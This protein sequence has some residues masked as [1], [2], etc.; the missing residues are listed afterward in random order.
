MR[1]VCAIGNLVG[2]ANSTFQHRLK[3]SFVADKRNVIFYMFDFIPN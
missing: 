1:S 2:K 3:A